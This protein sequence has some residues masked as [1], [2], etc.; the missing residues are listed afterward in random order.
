[1]T[2][3]TA[4]L[5]FGLLSLML[6]GIEIMFTYATLGFAHGFS[7]NRANVEKSELG[8]RI[9]NAYSNNAEAA[10]YGVPVLAA[11]AIVGL[12]GNGVETAA[13]LFVLG[14]V[15]FAVLYFTGI[16]F[17]RVPAFLIGTM[18]IFYI[19]IYLFLNL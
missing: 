2:F 15:A 11:A 17:V 12:E 3:T 9:S 14:R 8:K 5:A 7:A 16:T 13:M 6:A 18:S 10:A 19:A 1:M 4:L